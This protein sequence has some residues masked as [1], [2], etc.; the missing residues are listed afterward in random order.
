MTE[1][2]HFFM[3]TNQD[4]TT[5]P[6]L[7]LVLQSRR[8][9]PGSS[10]R[11]GAGCRT[12]PAMAPALFRVVAH[13]G[14]RLLAAAG[15]LSIFLLGQ[16]DAAAQVLAFPGAEGFG[17]FAKGGRG[18]D[19]YHVTTLS[20][21][22]P[23][24]LR[25]GIRSATG[26][27][28]IVFAVSGTIELKSRLTVDKSN[29][30]L[31][32]QTAPGDGITLRNYTFNIK[33]ATNVIVRYLRFRLGDENTGGGQDTMTTDDIDHVI[34]DHCS[35]SWAIDGTHDLRRGGNFT[36]QWCILSEALNNS[37]HQKGS[38]A[39]GAS[40][41]DLSGNVSLHHNLFST[42][43][44]RHP[45]LGSAKSPPQYL[46]D[47][48]NNV[49]YNWSAGGTAN[50]CDHFVNCVYNVW[51]PGPMSGTTLPIAM[52]GSLP[53]LS[54]GHMEGNVFEGRDELTRDNYAALDWE[55]W[56][57]PGTNYKY[58]G[59]LADWKSENV[60]LQ[61]ADTPR[62]QPAAEALELVLARAG[63]SL[64]RDAVDA[65]VIDNVRNRKGKVID[66]PKEVGGWPALR[67]GTAP[68]DTDRDGMPDDW[69]RAHGL[70]P[71]ESA[72]RNGDRNGDGYTNLEEYLA[73]CARSP[74]Q[75]P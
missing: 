19:V 51:R 34:L 41:R 15:L 62:T 49:I 48:R 33:N 12:G 45:T 64:H 55:R 36:L 53:D 67:P 14:L 22:G 61:A 8:L 26:P 43:R 47:F 30:T 13:D 4:P 11:D 2:N 40:Y 17:R 35:L 37:L 7:P 68:K 69:E 71:A 18:G 54:K 23:G 10:R 24:S 16:H 21:S 1:S 29:I 42:C 72:D 74:A 44:D 20:D 56:L 58:R 70:N 75:R 39:M 5:H 65:R 6:V 57:H 50:F 59:K 9:A 27:R 25:E 46:V 73:H 52:K 66:S 31:A 28:T 3:E 32:G 60:P 38:H 63:A